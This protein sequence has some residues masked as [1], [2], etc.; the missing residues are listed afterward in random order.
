MIPTNILQKRQ[1]KNKNI[2]TNNNTTNLNQQ[3]IIIIIIIIFVYDLV[4]LVYNRG[5]YI[6]S[7]NYLNTLRIH[8]ANQFRITSTYFITKNISILI[9]TNLVLRI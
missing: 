8:H 1:N 5:S 7:S 9:H 4:F 6:N 2:K 3:F